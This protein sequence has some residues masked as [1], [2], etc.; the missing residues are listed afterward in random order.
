MIFRKEEIVL[1]NPVGRIN[2]FCNKYNIHPEYN[3]EESVINNQRFFTVHLSVGN[4]VKNGLF[5]LY[6]YVYLFIEQ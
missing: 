3:F 1:N 4:I 6:I 2:E 5:H